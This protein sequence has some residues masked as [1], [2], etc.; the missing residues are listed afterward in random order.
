MPFAPPT[1]LAPKTKRGRSKIE[2]FTVL[3]VSACV[4]LYGCGGRAPNAAHAG[5][6]PAIRAVG[7]SA[8]AEAG[9]LPPPRLVSVSRSP[10]AL[11]LMGSAAPDAEV[12]LTAPEGDALG[13][14]A[15]RTGAWRLTLPAV[16]RPRMFAMAARLND[17]GSKARQVH[18]E[19]ALILLPRSGP[20]ALLVRAGAGA[21]VFAT[22]TVRPTLDAL[23]YDPGG[24]AAAAGRARPGAVVRLMMDG[25]LA[26]AGQADAGGR[27][28]ILAAN[29]RLPFGPHTA[30]VQAKDGQ[31]ER[32]FT[33]E[34]PGP[35]LTTNYKV[36]PTPEGWRLEWAIPGGGIQ[37]TL[38]F[39][40]AG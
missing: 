10:T 11:M 31:D 19:G 5:A 6:D 35:T 29:G 13:A 34:P 1:P 32:R 26:G 37:T 4:W 25:V 12:E 3:T 23:D 33:I 14:A 21:E 16:V 24:F 9:Y 28:S 36:D 40:P 8:G 27:Y 17:P 38:V 39:T 15:S 2:A 20:P 7:Q 30:L 18:S 22:P